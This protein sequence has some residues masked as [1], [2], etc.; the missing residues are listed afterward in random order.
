[1]DANGLKAIWP[2]IGTI[3]AAYWLRTGWPSIFAA[4]NGHGEAVAFNEAALRHDYVNGCGTSPALFV[5][6]AFVLTRR[7]VARAIIDAVTVWDGRW[8]TRKWRPTPTLPICPA[9]L[10]KKPPVSSK[11]SR[12]PISERRS[13]DWRSL[14]QPF[15]CLRQCD[16]E[17]AHVRRENG[18]TQ[19]IAVP[20][21]QDDP[22]H[23]FEIMDIAVHMI[24]EFRII[25]IM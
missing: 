13:A 14:P 3:F 9:M 4:L 18:D 5:K 7:D 21:R 11:P 22:E 16:I 20:R 25:I 24:A 23:R 6:K 17:F 1:M 15:D 2:I 12:S 19:R 10:S 8:D